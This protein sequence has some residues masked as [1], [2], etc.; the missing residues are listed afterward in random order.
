MKKIFKK[1][2]FFILLTLLI[3]I[4]FRS[5]SIAPGYPPYHPDEGA[6]YSRALKIEK[7]GLLHPEKYNLEL[8]Y[9]ATVAYINY[10]SFRYFWEP[11]YW[12][13]YYL[14]NFWTYFEG[15]ERLP[16]T[17][18]EINRIATLYIYGKNDIN[19]IYWARYTTT[20]FAILSVFVTYLLGKKISGERLGTLSAFMLAANHRHVLYSHLGLPEIY[21]GFFLLLAAYFSL[22][23]L[24]RGSKKDYLIN[25]I[26]TGLSFSIKLQLNAFFLLLTAHL[27]K[28]LKSHEI[29]K[30]IDKRIWIGM[31]SSLLT[32]ILINPFHVLYYDHIISLLSYTSLKYGIGN[33]LLHVFSY[34]YLWNFGLGHTTTTLFLIG[35]LIMLRR[36]K[37]LAL[38]LFSPIAYGLF[39]LTF[40]T[41]GGFYTRNFLMFF[42]LIVIFAAYSMDVLSEKASL[43]FTKK[44]YY[45]MAILLLLFATF[46]HIKRSYILVQNYNEP[47]NFVDLQSWLEQEI[48]TPSVVAATPSTPTPP[49]ANKVITLP[50]TEF[51]SSDEM[52]KIGAEYF[53]ISL[54]WPTNGFYFWMNTK[55]KYTNGK[56]TKPLEEMSNT[57]LG[58]VLY[59]YNDFA[60]KK[61]I[62]DWEAP[63]S[64]FI[65]SKIPDFSVQGKV[66]FRKYNFD[67]LDGWKV[68]DASKKPENTFKHT[69]GKIVIESGN[70]GIPNSRWKSEPLNMANWD[71]FV[72][73]AKIKTYSAAS[74]DGFVYVK[75]FRSLA[76]AQKSRNKITTR[77]SARNEANNKWNDLEL[78]GTVPK[79]TQY[80]VLGFQLYD[81]SVSSAKLDEI[82]VYNAKVDFDGSESY[83][84]KINE[85]IIFHETQSNL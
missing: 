17:E 4:Y 18:L 57:F 35:F 56:F 22:D 25:G 74:N 8:A 15:F 66:L 81:P 9:P 64:N 14:K 49:S 28:K 53:V 13:L 5:F 62:N 68:V 10:F 6:T 21:N 44:A 16:T 84:Q 11:Y 40:L 30:F 48:T 45:P 79:S 37:D 7:A 41:N 27:L 82:S 2:N 63:E 20:V 61:V 3:T 42:P 71:G 46:T 26:L 51:S 69:D 33:N 58:Y 50:I 47:W 23:I 75:F 73:Q 54:D 72:L 83:P 85:K 24:S 55:S 34:S 36:D 78:I 32:F 76:D 60:I 39:Y 1:S 59:E 70:K 43:L 65:V 31:I 52:R 29:K 80:A 19:T 77:V 12:L 67:S 38:L